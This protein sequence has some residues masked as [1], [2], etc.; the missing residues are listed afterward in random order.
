MCTNQR[1]TLYNT[2]IFRIFEIFCHGFH[3][4]LSIFQL[5]S[6]YDADL[7]TFRHCSSIFRRLNLFRYLIA[8]TIKPYFCNVEIYN[9]FRFVWFAAA[10]MIDL[11]S[12]RSKINRSIIHLFYI[13]NQLCLSHQT[14]REFIFGKDHIR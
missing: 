2:T 5:I 11:Q 9:I 7:K 8:K 10:S 6:I 4:I 1:L 13:V 12:N 3:R 14:F